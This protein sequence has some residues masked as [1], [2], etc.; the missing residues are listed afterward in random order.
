MADVEEMMCRQ[1]E[2]AIGDA[3]T[4]GGRC[5]KRPSTSAIQDVLVGLCMA[6]ATLHGDRP[7]ADAD[8]ELLLNCMFATLTNT[9]FDDEA[10]TAYVARLAERCRELRAASTAAL[11]SFM[12]AAFAQTLATPEAVLA[13]AG[14]FGARHMVALSG[15]TASGLV[16]F[17]LHSLKGVA[18]YADHVQLLGVAG[19]DVAAALA[20][21]VADIRALLERCCRALYL[22]AAGAEEA[23]QLVLD[24]GKAN[25]GV[26]LAL[27]AQHRAR[28]GDPTTT[29]VSVEMRPGKCILVTG[30]DLCDLEQLLVAT[31]G[32][33]ISVY[34]HGEM[35]PAHG[36]PQLNRFKHLAGHFG[37]SWGN[38]RKEMPAFPGAIVF[39][40]NCIQRPMPSYQDRVFTLHCVGW[41]GVA[42]LDAT[43]PDWT[44]AVVAKAQET[45]GFTAETAAACLPHIPRRPVL[46]GC[47][48]RA[49]LALAPEILGAVRSGAIK[50]FLYIGGCD[51][52]TPGRGYFQELARKADDSTVLL[53]SG[54]GRFRVIY[55]KDYGTVAGLP[56]VLDVGQCNDTVSAVLIAQALAEALEC[57]I[58]DL[59]LAL[60]VQW[61]EQKAMAILA[62]LLFLG[63][64]DRIWLGPT[65]AR[66]L[67]PDALA[68]LQERWGLRLTGDV[69]A[70]FEA[71]MALGA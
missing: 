32:T 44:A 70:D 58:N 17:A 6:L 2:M 57:G 51:G 7:L 38:Q 10:L 12:D 67:T 4:R 8:A 71:M 61:V 68:I 18:A 19:T 46:A 5:G 33:G 39:T 24:V 36:Y 29:P 23:L 43:D 25:M 55:E 9:N 31:E 13:V 40:T 3:C 45:E 21:V 69:D 65:A 42:H 59:P 64:K 11:P 48:H 14:P 22:T 60:A 50:H 27:D 47:S 66:H 52:P 53:T 28:F 62:T 54:C 37:S 56:R 1:C 16:E 30:H 49:V 20:P 63:I 34:T 35:L 15:E 26:M 41:P